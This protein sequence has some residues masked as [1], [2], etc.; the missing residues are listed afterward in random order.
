MEGISAFEALFGGGVQRKGK[1]C[2]TGMIPDRRIGRE[3][4]CRRASRIKR[5]G[6]R[7]HAACPEGMRRDTRKGRSGCRSYGSSVRKYTKSKRS[8]R[9]YENSPS[10]KHFGL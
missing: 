9:N 3:G 2:P 4:L 5:H 6:Y 7:R 8:P 1:L 10:K